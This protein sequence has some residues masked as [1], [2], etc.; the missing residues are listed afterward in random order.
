MSV[1]NINNNYNS[2]R[3]PQFIKPASQPA[4][5]A[6]ENLPADIQ[7]IQYMYDK[8]T[9]KNYMEGY[10]AKYNDLTV[11]GSPYGA[12]KWTTWYVELCGPV[13][14]MWDA[15]TPTTV[16]EEGETAP[17][18]PQ[19][20]NLAD[21]NVYISDEQNGVFALNSAGSNRFLFQPV[22]N[23]PFQSLLWVS[24]IRLSCFEWSR[25]HQIYT[26]KFTQRYNNEVVAVTKPNP[27]MEGYIQ[28]RLPGETGWQKYWAI[29]SDRRDEKTL[30][31]KKKVPT[32]AQLVFYENKKQK[33]PIFTI[34]NIVNTYTLYPESPQLIDIATILKVEGS[35]SSGKYDHQQENN[36]TETSS[37]L[38]MTSS[39]NEL[40]QWL[41]A[42]FDS[43]K[44]YGR[45]DTFFDD[46]Y[47]VNALNFGD[48]NNIDSRLFL[49]LGDIQH[50]N[51]TQDSF[52][53]NKISFS[54]VLLQKMQGHI[55]TAATSTTEHI[56]QPYHNNYPSE[57]LVN[58]TVPDSD[59]LQPTMTR[60]ITNHTDYS[61]S[62]T[63][64]QEN[65]RTIAPS[66][67]GRGGKLIYA[68]DDSEEDDNHEDG[69][70]EDESDDDDDDVII[71]KNSTLSLPKLNSINLN[72]ENKN[73]DNNESK[74]E[75][76]EVLEDDDDNS[77]ISDVSETSIKEEKEKKVISTPARNRQ[78]SA[79]PQ[80]SVSGSGT[81]SEDDEEED[82]DDYSSDDDDKKLSDLR[83]QGSSS[84]L[85]LADQQD[86]YFDQQ[87]DG[88]IYDPSTG[89][90]YDPAQYEHPQFGVHADI[91]IGEDGPVIPEL[92]SNFAT[93]NSLLDTYRPDH[94]NARDQ[95]EYARQ[96]GSTLLHV[97]EKPPEPSMGLVGMISQIEGEKKSSSKGRLVQREKEKLLERERERYLW[98]QRQ[99]MLP[100]M[101]QPPLM[102]Q[103]NSSQP[104]LLSQMNNNQMNNNQML[105]MNQMNT[106][107][108]MGM[109]QM[110]NSQM[111]GQFGMLQPPMMDP[112]MS[113]MDPRMSMMGQMPPMMMGQLPMM[114]Q[115]ASM[116]PPMMMG[117]LPMM[118]Q[119]ASM[120]NMQMMMA[121]YQ[122]N[123]LLYNQQLQANRFG[124][125]MT[126]N[127]L[128]EDD[129]ED[130]DVPLGGQRNDQT[131]K[132]KH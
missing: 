125:S 114:D 23:A 42:I 77:T 3:P 74:L 30:F 51:N 95:I 22:E 48:M 64:S 116:M 69:D 34:T 82:E 8:Y 54:D 65:R 101:N 29:V 131:A 96:T 14:T 56:N 13:L 4:M 2:I 129:D 100:Q 124:S 108:M 45:P 87:P 12:D 73:E 88:A 62:N 5:N 117:Q 61:S 94:P 123:G 122:N 57:N 19:Y 24:A 119:R 121:M 26:K 109:N 25:I 46:I 120:M 89:M 76:K 31:G 110:N 41:V 112:R 99:Q 58:P 127:D 85:L 115:R 38:I 80:A 97:P 33:Q 92:G 44:L 1:R 55:P 79:R 126:L 18:I 20:I 47:N 72:N 59:D 39:R 118:D 49:E 130:D 66:T 32:Q 111:M 40:I 37:A 36:N 53:Q 132:T 15:E 106:N 50:I 128:N 67:S 35:S 68:S 70:D 102:N 90:Y 104:T 21:A 78:R 28:V 9:E 27:K 6:I 83:Q 63:N 7:A 71:S 91:Q 11:D 86:Q 52:A 10:L 60:S 103:M 16:N 17:V 81:E 75:N 84:Q 105:G 98:E 43:F 107:Q 113:M 93:Q